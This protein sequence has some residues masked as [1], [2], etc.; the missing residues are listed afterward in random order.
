MVSWQ[1]ALVGLLIAHCGA[2]MP[3]SRYG[4]QDTGCLFIDVAFRRETFRDDLT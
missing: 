2:A 3:L 4:R 1:L